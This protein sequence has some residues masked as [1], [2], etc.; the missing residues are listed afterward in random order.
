[1]FTDVFPPSVNGV[2]SSILLLSKELVKRGHYVKV[3]TSSIDKK[4]RLTKKKLEGIEVS[5][6]TS[7]PSL[8]YPDVKLGVPF[9]PNTVY[10]LMKD[11]IDVVHFHTPLPMGADGII[12]GKM[13]G[14]PIVGTFHTYFMEPEYLKVIG[15]NIMGDKVNNMLAKLGWKYANLYYNSADLVTT[16]TES[17]RKAL[18]KYKIKRPTKTI[19]NGIRVP[20]LPK[21][22]LTKHHASNNL[23]YV[24]RLSREKNL[25]ILIKAF[26]IVHDKKSELRLIIIGDGPAQN[27]LEE[28][29]HTEG[30]EKF[31][32]FKGKIPF[33][34]LLESNTY[35]DAAMFVSASTSET[36]GLSI[37]EGMSYGLPV[38]AVAKRG[39]PELIKDNGLMSKTAN[40]KDIAINILKII[41]NPVLAKKMSLAS[42]KR[43]DKYS[44]ETITTQFEHVYQK[45]IEQKR[46]ADKKTENSF[47]KKVTKS[48]KSTVKG[49][50]G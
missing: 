21:E 16:P 42:I 20:H 33:E 49:L 39:I 36:Q 43:A 5:Y 27:D 12:A 18:V 45:L 6:S 34:K 1:M 38:V 23:L 11:D 41:E 46:I 14:K 25:D 30:L 4:N 37:I 15:L 31:I 7:L 32:H 44:I 50:L 48:M 26:K 17:T 29:A 10:Q 8:F 9:Y 19:S 2:A 13:L 3:F 35:V 28:L 40:A 22:K 47:M 24:G